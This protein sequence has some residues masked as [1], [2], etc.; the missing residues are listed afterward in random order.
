MLSGN[1][2][3]VRIARADVDFD[4]W[5]T[6]FKVDD[7]WFVLEYRD[8]YIRQ[9]KLEQAVGP[10]PLG[11]GGPPRMTRRQLGAPPAHIGPRPRV[12][13][14]RDEPKGARAAKPAQPQ[15]AGAPPKKRKSKG[16]RAER[17]LNN[18]YNKL[19]WQI[20]LQC[21]DVAKILSQRWLQFKPR[22]LRTL[23][24]MRRIERPC[25]NALRVWCEGVATFVQT[26]RQFALLA[27][28]ANSLFTGARERASHTFGPAG[29]LEP[30]CTG[31]N[32]GLNILIYSWIWD[33]PPVD[34][35]QYLFGV[36]W[37]KNLFGDPPKEEQAFP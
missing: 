13:T 18:L 10:A 19:R 24:E 25:G 27:D 21:D 5:W 6:P 34:W 15:Q 29:R 28:R 17:T 26:H 7:L 22:L 8:T 14:K 30:R 1:I 31:H 9:Y 4:A 2:E 12:R 16:S 11:G 33:E 3:L 23:V 35:S 37:S 20:L 36:D 32:T